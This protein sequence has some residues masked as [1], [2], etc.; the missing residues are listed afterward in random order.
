[1]TVH[2]FVLKEMETKTKIAL[3]LPQQSRNSLCYI[4]DTG[5]NRFSDSGEDGGGGG[6][7]GGDD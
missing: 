2:A 7:G 5:P 6:G 1:M 3:T 4:K